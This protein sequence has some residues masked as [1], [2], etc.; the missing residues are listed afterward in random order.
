[1]E[2]LHRVARSSTF[3]ILDA[4]FKVEPDR[5]R[6]VALTGRKSQLF[7]HAPPEVIGER[8]LTRAASGRRHPI[9]RDAMHPQRMAEGVQKLAATSAPLELDVPT[10]RVDT[11]LPVNEEAI[12]A[13]A[14]NGLGID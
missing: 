14:R 11:S 3:A 5:E 12:L 4:N 1:M 8:L 13:W 6:L 7:C 10:P 2:V 9:H